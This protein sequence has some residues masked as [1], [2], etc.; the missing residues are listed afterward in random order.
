MA[1]GSHTSGERIL[2]QMP[3]AKS[4]GKIH[5]NRQGLPI[6]IR[7][8]I[9]ASIKEKMVTTSAARV[10]GRRHSACAR[11]RMAESMTP[12]WLIPIQN[13]KLVMKKAHITGRFSPV[14]PRPRANI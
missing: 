3:R 4:H 2:G 10:A 8:I 9:R 12:A 13:T 6:C 14:T 7:G 1:E 11:R 5:K